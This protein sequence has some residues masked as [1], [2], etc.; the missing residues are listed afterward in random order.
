[1]PNQVPT[2]VTQEEFL[3]AIKPLCDLVGV[4]VNEIY[5]DIHIVGAPQKSAAFARIS[6][7]VVARAADDDRDR[8]D[9]VHLA[10]APQ[11]HA[12]LAYPVYVDV[13]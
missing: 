12:E 9:G 10:D 11:E 5:C 7:A 3:A 1:M 13:I 4:S 2:T 8:P 6:M